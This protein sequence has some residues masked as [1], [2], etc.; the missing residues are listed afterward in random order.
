MGPE[1]GTRC[2]LVAVDPVRPF[3]S[4]QGRF[5]FLLVLALQ[6]AGAQRLTG[7]RE[8]RSGGAALRAAL[9]SKRR[10]VPL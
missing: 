8:G 1:F 5:V 10:F 3:R 7:G 9:G 6:H 4:E 2:A